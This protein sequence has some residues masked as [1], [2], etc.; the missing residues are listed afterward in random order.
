MEEVDPEA[1]AASARV[2][3]CD[4][5]AESDRL[6]VGDGGAP[7]GRGGVGEADTEPE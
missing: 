1:P 7:G 4:R 6:G 2:G 3:D 5:V